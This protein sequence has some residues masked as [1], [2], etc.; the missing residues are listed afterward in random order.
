MAFSGAHAQTAQT[1]QPDAAEAC[2][3]LAER[4]AS[5]SSVGENVRTEVEEIISSG[6]VIQCELIFTAWEKEGALADETLTLVATEEATQRLIV[7]QEVEVGAEAAV[8]QP[9][10][11][12]EV[13]AGAPEVVWNMP[14]QSVTVEQ[15]APQV[16]FRQAQ[17]RISVEVPQPRVTVTIPE[18]EVIV[19]W[20]DATVDMAAIEPNIEVR[21]PEPSVSVMMPEP[22]VEVV[23]GGG[24]P[25]DLVQLDDGRFAPRGASVEDLE[26]R[27]AINQEEAVVSRGQESE[28]PEVVVNRANPDVTIEAAEPEVTVNVVGE[29]QIE[30]NQ[31]R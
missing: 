31:S 5:D 10:A 4:L 6:D 7:Q 8:Y 21:I 23:I 27:I 26:P 19:T 20:P 24:T 12:V 25:E 9:P 18:P 15:P 1:D 22:I 11:E 28:A 17:P 29:P 30:V 14:R 3:N 2:A 16:T 13:D